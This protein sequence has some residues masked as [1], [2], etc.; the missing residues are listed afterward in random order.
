VIERD[1]IV[2]A[3]VLKQFARAQDELNKKGA[4][5]EVTKA[6]ALE[7]IARNA[8]DARVTEDG[9]PAPLVVPRHPASREGRQARA[10]GTRPPQADHREGRHVAGGW[11]DRV[12][13]RALPNDQDST[14]I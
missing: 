9:T 3:S 11:R 6:E 14:S 8:K 7:I 13:V 12:R 1:L 5:G 2:A 10:R 4:S